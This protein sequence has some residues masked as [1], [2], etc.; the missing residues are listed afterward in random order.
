MAEN[1]LARIEY[2]VMQFNPS[3]ASLTVVDS[4]AYDASSRQAALDDAEQAAQQ[5]RANNQPRTYTVIR[6]AT[7]ATYET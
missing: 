2:L 4:V 5:A 3:D 6:I 1:P 7:E